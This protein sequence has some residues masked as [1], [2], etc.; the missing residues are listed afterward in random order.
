MH[1]NG[2][3]ADVKTAFA[4][5]PVYDDRSAHAANTNIHTKTIKSHHPHKHT[6]TNTILTCSDLI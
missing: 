2:F 5:V 6:H 1:S 4:D 3:C